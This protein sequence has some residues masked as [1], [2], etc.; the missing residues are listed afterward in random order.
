MEYI[1]IEKNRVVNI[2]CGPSVPKGMRAVADNHHFRVGDDVR[3]FRKDGKRMT[4][5]E[6]AKEGLIKIG[7]HQAAVWVKGQYKA[8]DDY[9]G[10]KYWNKETG[11]LVKL[12][13]GQTPDNTLTEVERTDSASKWED[14]EWVIPDE[15]KAKRIRSKR[16]EALSKT[17][18]LLMPDYPLKDKK[19]WE[20]YRQSLR[21]IPQQT[22]FPGVV[23]WPEAP[24]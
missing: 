24:V 21:D 6:A 4:P 11:Q 9:S 23:R 10:I 16:N 3:F 12:R 8:V 15:V 1:Q 19:K 2:F 22:G 7:D 14:G 17:D 18:Y 5:E 20:E 13:P